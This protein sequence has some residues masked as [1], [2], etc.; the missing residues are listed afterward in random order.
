M[1]PEWAT[2]MEEFGI[3]WMPYTVET[4]DGWTLTMFRLTGRIDKNDDMTS[5][6]NGK[7]PVIIQHGGGMDATSWSVSAD[8]A[9]E[10]NTIAGYPS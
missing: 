4:E 1:Y 10:T 3:T 2:K 6:E 5:C 7:Y 9:E 8:L